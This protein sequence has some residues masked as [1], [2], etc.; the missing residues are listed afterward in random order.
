MRKAN[1]SDKELV[2]EI[3]ADS[4][5]ENQRINWV[6]KNDHKRRLR[7]RELAL[8]AFKTALKRDGVL[9]SSDEKGVALCYRYNKKRDSIL[10]YYNKLRLGIK[11][12][13]I[14]RIPMILKRMA[15]VRNKRPKSGN[16]L[17]FWF[18][19]VAKEARG[20]ESAYE[21]SNQIFSESKEKDLM[22]Y[23][24]TSDR[25]NSIIYER[26]GFETYH[27]WDDREKGIKLWLMKR[28][29]DYIG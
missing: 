11:T 18:F 7:I 1:R 2:V 28:S 27:F 4:F 13:G 8:Y 6:I 19:A 10:D 23:A 26:F 15:F 14:T 29:P 20:K 9:I 12:I 3:I 24:E 17:Y 21:L 22:V 25:R 16:Y 5:N